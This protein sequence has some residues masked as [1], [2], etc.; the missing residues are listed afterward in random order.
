MEQGEEIP[1]LTARKGSDGKTYKEPEN[2]P[3]TAKTAREQAKKPFY[4]A[5]EAPGDAQ[6][7]PLD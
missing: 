1:T 4:S 5:P 3:K 6:N 2:T 7:D